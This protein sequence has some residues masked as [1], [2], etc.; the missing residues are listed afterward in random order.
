MFKGI[1][2]NIYNGICISPEFMS[3]ITIDINSNHCDIYENQ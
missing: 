1:N 2:Y 3:K